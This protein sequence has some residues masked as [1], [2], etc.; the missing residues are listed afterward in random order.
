MTS[1][2]L[3]LIA[4]IVQGPIVTPLSRDRLQPFA[5]LA[6]LSTLAPPQ[7]NPGAEAYVSEGGSRVVK[8]V[9]VTTRW[10]ATLVSVTGIDGPFF[11]DG[12]I[13]AQP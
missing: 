5:S 13:R 3:P 1:E 2:A 11:E 6:E 7:F 12:V 8:Y 10:V 9:S 4:S